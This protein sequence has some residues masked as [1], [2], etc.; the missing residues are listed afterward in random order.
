MKLRTYKKNYK[1]DVVHKKFEMIEDK[2]N[3]LKESFDLK[4]EEKF[5]KTNIGEKF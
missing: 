3:E 4:M 2:V 5:K 1:I